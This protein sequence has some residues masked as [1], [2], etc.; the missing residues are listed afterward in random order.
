MFVRKFLGI[1]LGVAAND[2]LLCGQWM[3]YGGARSKRGHFDLQ[4]SGSFC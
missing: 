4:G 1:F 2:V 3:S